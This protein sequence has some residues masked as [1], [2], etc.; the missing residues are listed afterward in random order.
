MT[1]WSTNYLLSRS[2][3]WNTEMFERKLILEHFD[4]KWGWIFFAPIS[5]YGKRF[6]LFTDHKPLTYMFSLKDPNDKMVRW[7]LRLQEFDYEVKFRPGRQNV[8]ADGLSRIPNQEVNSNDVDEASEVATCHSADTDDGNFIPMTELPINFFRNQIILKKGDVDANDYE[9][10]FPK[11]HRR[12]ITRT[13][14]TVGRVLDIFKQYMNPRGINCIMCE[15]SLMNILQIVYRNYFSRCKTFNVRMSQKI[16]L[17]LRSPEEQN[18]IVARTH[19]RAHRGAQ[20]NHK[21]IIKEY[22]FPAMKRQIQRYVNLCG[23][24][25][26]NKYERNPYHITLHKPEIPN[27][28][29]EVVHLDIFISQPNLF[30]TI[31][32][33]FTRFGSL[34]HIKSRSIP[35][36]R[37][38]LIK[39]IS[40]YATPKRIVCDNEP[41]LKSIE[42]RSLLQRLNIEVHYVPSNHSE[43]NGIVERFHS[44]LNEIFRCIKDKYD[45][46]DQKQIYKIAV[47][48]YNKT[49]HTAHGHKP[50][51]ILFGQKETQE[52]PLDIDK[53]FENRQELIDE[54]TLRLN[55]T[56]QQDIDYHNKNREKQPN[57]ETHEEV[58][59]TV[60][61]IKKKTKPKFKRVTVRQN[62]H[63]TVIDTKGIKI[64]KSKLKRKRKT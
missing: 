59:N 58:F 35:D 12:V 60:Q 8:V 36:V 14:F 30:L 34:I 53:L 5:A 38:G 17:D 9:E 46:L 42:I 54:V 31:V 48:L 57:F 24:C 50:S 15:E 41:A 56:A 3:Y 13:D 33:K 2:I 27:K 39:M 61:G 37:A 26:E 25:L 22:Y 32:D 63:K 29:F 49:I 21:Q 1:K 20:E 16:L 6:T 64:H 51:E 10:V 47:A 40:L 55:K 23:V 52:L 45:D 43:S 44:T 11:T 62:R 19:D 18:E 28:P 7:R 4:F